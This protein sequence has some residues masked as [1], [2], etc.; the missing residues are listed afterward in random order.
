LSV[1]SSTTIICFKLGSGKVR[2]RLGE[3]CDI[4]GLPQMSLRNL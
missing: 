1:P 2:V 4:Y 3:Y